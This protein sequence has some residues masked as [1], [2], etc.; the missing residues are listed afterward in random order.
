MHDT[1]RTRRVNSRNPSTTTS[2]QTS[3]ATSPTAGERSTADGPIISHKLGRSPPRTRP[4]SNQ[5][6]R[7]PG[8]PVVNQQAETSQ[9]AIAALQDQAEQ[10]VDEPQANLHVDPAVPQQNLQAERQNLAEGQ[11]AQVGELQ[12]ALHRAAAD[13]QARELDAAQ[14]QLDEDLQAE[15]AEASNK[16]ENN[17]FKYR[18]GAGTSWEQAHHIINQST[19]QV[20]RQT[21]NKKRSW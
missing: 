8:A 7:P 15:M 12:A 13:Q 2:L 1:D 14:Q 19:L 20:D 18:P 21:H 17:T 4:T 10:Q 16:E 11:A 9:S 6:R 3:R 5:Q